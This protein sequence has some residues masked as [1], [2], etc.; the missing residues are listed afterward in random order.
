MMLSCLLG[1]PCRVGAQPAPDEDPPLAG[2]ASFGL[3]VTDGNSQTLSLNFGGRISYTLA[4]HTW[5]FSTNVLR[6]RDSGE[7]KANKGSLTLRYDYEP[8]ERVYVTTQMAASYNRPA[9]IERRLSPGLG[10]GYD[11]VRAE[12][13]RLSLDGGL[14]WVGERFT[15]DTRENSVYFNLAQEFRLRVNE[16]TDL[17]QRLTYSP[18]PENL[19]DYLI[20]GSLTLTTRV[21][22]LL[23]IK[24]EISDD[25]DS[26]PFIDPDTG[27][28]RSSNDLTF[29]TG[30]SVSF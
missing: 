28:A 9:G 15:D 13:T 4:K 30:L 20:Q 6:T 12:S 7:V 19:G 27:V 16:T 14:N 24:T 5:A 1:A 18:R 8:S 23:G 26:T 3:T 17:A 21:W 10:L 11:M 25:Y 29:I 22:K 2:T